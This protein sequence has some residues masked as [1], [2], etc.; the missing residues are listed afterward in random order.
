LNPKERILTALKGGTPGRVPVAAQLSLIGS[1]ITESD[2]R[3]LRA[4]WDYW[5]V[6][7]ESHLRL[8]IDS[9]QTW[10]EPVEFNVHWKEGWG[11]WEQTLEHGRDYWLVE[12]KIETPYGN[13]SSRVKRTPVT[14][15]ILKDLVGGPKDWEI[16]KAYL[17][18]WLRLAEP[19]VERYD[20]AVE[21]LGDRGVLTF[22]LNAAWDSLGNVRGFEN[23]I[24]DTFRHP[25]LVKELVEV[26]RKVM[27]KHLEFF[28]ECKGE[29]LQFIPYYAAQASPKIFKDWELQDLQAVMNKVRKNRVVGVYLCGPMKHFLPYLVE[30]GVDYVEDFP[31]YS[32]G[33]DI[34]LGEA[35][36]KYG[37]QI[38]L[39]GGFNILLLAP[40]G[41]PDEIKVD[42]KRCMDEAKEGGGYVFGTTDNVPYEANIENVKLMVETAKKYA[43]Y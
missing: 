36:K 34:T 20:A 28:N 27:M 8:G 17:E 22:H 6:E 19:N 2:W 11:D 39:L 15:W 24:A 1:R 3:R 33:G 18:E 9:F 35:K 43:P 12:R 23:M 7:Y 41:T 14:N 32:M 42:V 40:P 31:P 13:L 16:Y 25:D 21:E 10:G 38:C 29:A 26:D 4:R 37:K 5:R 30:A